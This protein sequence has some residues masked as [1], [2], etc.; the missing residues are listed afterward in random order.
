MVTA[1]DSVQQDDLEDSENEAMATLQKEKA[2][3]CMPVTNLPG[4]EGALFCVTETFPFPLLPS[5]TLEDSTL[6]EQ[7][8]GSRSSHQSGSLVTGR[9]NGEKIPVQSKLEESKNFR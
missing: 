5:T 8:G 3:R 1:N 2:S 7:S 9:S 6:P 4:I